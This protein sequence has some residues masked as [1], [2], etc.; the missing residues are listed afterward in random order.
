[1]TGNLSRSRRRPRSG[2]RRSRR[3]FSFVV[4]ASQHPTGPEGVLPGRAARRRRKGTESTGWSESRAARIAG[5]EQQTVI[6][7]AR[8][9]ITSPSAGTP[10][11]SRSRARTAHELYG[12]SPPTVAR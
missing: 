4:T 11:S 6:V 5:G 3:M 1:M 9:P 2:C 10:S 7:T 12:E 8:P